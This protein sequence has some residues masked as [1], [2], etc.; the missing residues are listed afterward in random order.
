VPGAWDKWS[1]YQE[2]A[3][4]HC[5]YRHA[6]STHT[7]VS[8]D[9]SASV[10]VRQESQLP[11]EPGDMPETSGEVWTTFEGD[12]MWQCALKDMP[13]ALECAWRKQATPLLIDMTSPDRQGPSLLSLSSRTRTH[14][15]AGARAL[16]STRQPPVRV[17][18]H[19]RTPTPTIYLSFHD[20]YRSTAESFGAAHAICLTPES[21]RGCCTGPHAPRALSLLLSLALSI[22][23]YLS[24][25]RLTPRTQARM[26]TL[27]LALFLRR[28]N[29]NSRSLFANISR[30]H[31]PC[32]TRPRPPLAGSLLLSLILLNIFALPHIT[33]KL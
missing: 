31:A 17:H 8:S 11:A 29:V 13:K 15:R 12:Y 19:T 25:S 33:P 9:S 1:S 10:A 18:A 6:E 5:K 20:P 2:M 22:F 27:S 16:R 32:L 7:A 21:V 30:A 26:H 23:L 28:V 3:C 4:D 24:P 14:V